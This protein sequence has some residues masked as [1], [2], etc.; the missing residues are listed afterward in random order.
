MSHLVLIAAFPLDARMWEPVAFDL[1]A[2]GHR[3]DALDL[4]GL[5]TGPVLAGEPGLR[6]AAAYVHGHLEVGSVV[7][8]VSMGG[9]VIMELLRLSRDAGTPT[10]PAAIALCD[11]K[12]TADSE[13]GR[14]GRLAMAAAIEADAAA[15]PRLLRESVLPGLLRAQPD[16]HDLALVGQWLEEAPPASVAWYQ[17][18]MADRPDSR[19]DLAGFDGPALVLWGDDD[20]ISPDAEQQLTI[21]ALQ[22]P[23]AVRIPGA[24]HLACVE[25]P[26]PVAQALAAW[27]E[28]I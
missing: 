5:G 27:L 2:A 14:A 28:T 15:S 12:S 21:E 17:R 24:G 16:P 9:Y 4:P 8:G 10:L 25:R 6:E 13:A 11:T 20:R 3:V 22:H 26:A 18:A 7:A 1:R 23:S 19:P